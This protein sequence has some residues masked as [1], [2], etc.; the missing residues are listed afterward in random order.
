MPLLAGETL[1]GHMERQAPLPAAEVIRIG[2]ELAEALAAVH[3]KGLIH[4]DLKPSN[5][6]LEAPRDRVKLLDFGLARDPRADDALTSPGTLVGTLAYM[7]PEQANGLPLDARSDLFSLGSVLYETATGRAAF[8]APTQTALLHAVG[9]TQP[10]P[11]R[12]VNPAIP[13]ALSDLLGRLHQKRPEDRPASAAVV[14]KELDQMVAEPGAPTRLSGSRPDRTRP[15]AGPGPRSRIAVASGGGWLLI[16]AAIL[17]Y[18]LL[19]R[20]REKAAA[21]EPSTAPVLAAEPLRVRDLSVL[22][23]EGVDEKKTDPRGVLG[24]D[25]FGATPQ[26]DIKVTARLTRAGLLL[27]GRVPTGWVG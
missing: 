22:H 5:I 10:P 19:N 7:S 16:F 21:T 4:R 2:R 6:W 12:T 8:A 14:M 26:D 11:A 23:F 27:P 9:E 15:T 13:M 24:K 18:S 20:P 17:A 3:A 1:A 25:S